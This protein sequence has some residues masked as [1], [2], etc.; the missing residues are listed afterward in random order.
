MK[1]QTREYQNK[2]RKDLMNLFAKLQAYEKTIWSERSGPTEEYM[3]RAAENILKDVKEKQGK[4]FISY[5]ES[6]PIGY[7]AGYVGKD[8][9]NDADYFH[10]DALFVDERFRGKGIGTNLLKKIEEHAKSIGQTKIGLGVLA[11]NIRSHNYYKKI[12][13][14]DYDILL[15]KDL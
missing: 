9:E 4:I 12:G 3:N 2:Y 15:L 6:N 14:K 1:I 10:V 5:D 13:F 11:G 8:I 7:I